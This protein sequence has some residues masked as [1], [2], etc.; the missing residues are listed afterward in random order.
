MQSERAIRESYLGDS[1]LLRAARTVATSLPSRT[2]T[3]RTAGI[4]QLA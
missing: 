3:H 1:K 4:G 2:R